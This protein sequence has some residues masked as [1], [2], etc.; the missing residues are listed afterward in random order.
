MSNTDKPKTIIQCDFDGTLTREDVGFMLLDVFARR[1]WR[2]TLDQYKAGLI[3]V[4]QFNSRVFSMIEA[5]KAELLD[6]VSKRRISLRAGFPELLEGCRRRGFEFVI[7][8]NGWDFYIDYIMQGLGMG[9]VPVRAS[10][11]SFDHGNHS[12]R[13]IGPDGEELQEGFKE[14][15]SRF[16]LDR[17]YRVVYVGNGVSDV[18]AAR[19]AHYVFAIDDLHEYFQSR[20]YGCQAF[21]DMF[22]IESNLDRLA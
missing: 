3:T 9:N 22:D 1:G 14:A 8:S 15:Y 6:Y 4:G 7:V 19:M 10:V 18:P 2:T 12:A 17:G 11:T 20:N 13:Y 21:Q 16:F 5:G